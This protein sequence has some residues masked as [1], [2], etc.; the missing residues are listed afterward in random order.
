MTSLTD[1]SVDDI[2]NVLADSQKSETPKT[3]GDVDSEANEKNR[4]FTFVTRLLLL[5]YIQRFRQSRQAKKRKSKDNDT[6]LESKTELQKEEEIN[7]LWF[8]F[9]QNFT[10]HGFRYVFE[11]GALL[12]RLLWLLVLIVAIGAVTIQTQRSIRKYF[13]RPIRTTV[14]LKYSDEIILPAV[15]ICNFNFFPHYLINGTVGE[16][17]RTSC[18][19]VCYSFV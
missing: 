11:K 5:D 1:K 12:R 6:L 9:M 19:S 7:I 16:R 14:S 15:T 17:V 2:L 10:L 18:S 13:R 4:I 3:K 8:T